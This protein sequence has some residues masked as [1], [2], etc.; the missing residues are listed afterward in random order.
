MKHSFIENKA[1]VSEESGRKVLRDTLLIL[2]VMLAI[3][4]IT[5]LYAI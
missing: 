3:G 1:E 2:G 4:V 5:I